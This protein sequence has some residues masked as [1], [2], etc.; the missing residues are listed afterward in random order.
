MLIFRLM[1]LRSRRVYD[2]RKRRLTTDK[3]DLTRYH[4]YLKRQKE[5]KSNLLLK[6]LVLKL[7]KLLKL[8]EFYL[9][10]E[11]QLRII[12]RLCSVWRRC[13][14]SCTRGILLVEDSVLEALHLEEV[15]E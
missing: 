6:Y 4:K 10:F 5:K 15:V 2:G 8:S 3:S 14:R 1:I 7:L 9:L 12:G 13:G 11:Q